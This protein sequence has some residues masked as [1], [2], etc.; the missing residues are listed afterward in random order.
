MWEERR[1]W[2]AEVGGGNVSTRKKEGWK[3]KENLDRYCEAGFGD[4]MSG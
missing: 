3:T 2:N 1:G 4:I